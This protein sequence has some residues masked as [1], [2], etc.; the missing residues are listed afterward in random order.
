M[1]N[2][3]SFT[4]PVVLAAAALTAGCQQM[5]GPD[6]DSEYTAPRAGYVSVQG[7]GGRSLG[8]A[9]PPELV[10]R[11]GESRALRLDVERVNFRDP[12]RVSVSQ[13]PRGVQ[14]D[15]ASRNV[16]ATSTTFVLRASQDA[17]LVHNHFVVVSVEGPD[18]MR[19]SDNVRLTVLD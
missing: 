12:V 4:G 7:T 15:D 1:R 10:L 9:S 14:V 11:R 8:L 3:T 2:L 19:A 18:S 13:L 17:T 6:R 5:F 16:D